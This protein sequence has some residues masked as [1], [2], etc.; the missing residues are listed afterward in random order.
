[1]GESNLVSEMQYDAVWYRMILHVT[2]LKH[3]SDFKLTKIPITQGMDIF[4][5][6]LENNTHQTNGVLQDCGT[7]L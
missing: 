6:T 5:S 1:M 3:G 4:A 7:H 2:K